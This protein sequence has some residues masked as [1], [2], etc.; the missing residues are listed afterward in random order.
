MSYPN[1]LIFVDFPSDDPEASAAFY[2]AVFGWEVEPRPAG[3]FHRIV[4][5]QNFLLDDGS[6]SPTGNLHMGIFNVANA[7]PHPD[8]DGVEPRGLCTDGRAARVWILVSDDDS[9]DRIMDKAVELGATELW[10]NHYWA[11]FN[12]FNAAFRDPWGNDMVLWT[13]AGDDPTM[14]EGWSHE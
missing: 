9:S 7:R 2:E 13:K 8:P 10:R 12:G 4:P 5:G 1:T 11:E 3:V 14:P 6:Q